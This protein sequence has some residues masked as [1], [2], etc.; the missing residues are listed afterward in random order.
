MAFLKWFGFALV[1][2]GLVVRIM[3]DYFPSS[4][5]FSENVGILTSILM[6]IIGS[7]IMVRAPQR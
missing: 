5:P 6:I 4:L 7:I 1:I 2:L 3:I